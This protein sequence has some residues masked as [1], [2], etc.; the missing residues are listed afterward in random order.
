MNE[1]TQAIL[2]RR[3]SGSVLALGLTLL[4]AACGRSE[5]SRPAAVTGSPQQS[6][7]RNPAAAPTGDLRIDVEGCAGIGVADAAVLL[8]VAAESLEARSSTETWGTDCNYFPHGNELDVHALSFSI[9]RAESAA[10]AAEEMA[11]LAG[12]A[13]V[14]DQVLPGQGASHRVAGLGDEALWV[15]ANRSL[16][17]RTGAVSFIVTRP[18]E[19]ARQIE[20]A[21]RILR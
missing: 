20:V 7:S 10:E 21:R 1:P 18:E 14:S 15:A 13:G 16:Y 5:P 19:E 17:V 9:S 12:H 2:I 11:Q 3:R 4:V 6:A 8:G